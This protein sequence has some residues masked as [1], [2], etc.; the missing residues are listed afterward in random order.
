MSV[1]TP[2][3]RLIVTER[4]GMSDAD[5]GKLVRRA[6]SSCGVVRVSV[7][8]RAGKERVVAVREERLI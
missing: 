1:T 3:T 4:R 6:L 5:L 2:G 8:G 7:L